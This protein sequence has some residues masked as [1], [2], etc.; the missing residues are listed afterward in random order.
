MIVLMPMAGGDEAFQE[1]GY[2]YPKPLIEIQGKSLLEHA[3]QGLKSLPVKQH[4]FVIRKE[5]ARSSY[6]QDVLALLSPE[7]AV[8]QADGPTAG[9]ACTA[10]L[11]IEHIRRD[12][13]LLIVNGDQVFNCDLSVAIQDFH[14]RNL[15]AGTIAFDSVHPRWSFVRVNAEGLVS[16]AAEKRPI[17]RFATAG[18]YWFRRGGDFVDAA[19]AMIR[20]NAHVGGRF[21]V[22]PTFNELILKNARI[23]VHKIPREDYVSLAT[24]QNVEEYEQRLGQTR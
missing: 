3:W 7:S 8:V 2:A 22:C 6:L 23:G 19:F 17:S 5:D 4:V 15:D 20:K 11:A 24:P 10:L 14:D 16:E 12:H 9:A 18:F 21:Y 13:E 1:R